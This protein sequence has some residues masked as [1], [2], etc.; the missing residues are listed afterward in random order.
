VGLGILQK[1]WRWFEKLDRYLSN[2]GADLAALCIFGMLVVIT[3]SSIGR[4]LF[5]INIPNVDEFSGYALVFMTYLGLAYGL[6]TGSHIS[7]D[8][9]RAKLPKSVAVG[10]E[11]VTC[12]IGLFVVGAYF[13]FALDALMESLRIGERALTPSETPLWI[14]RSAICVGW[15]FMGL[16]M[17][18]LLVVKLRSFLK[19]LMKGD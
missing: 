2:A 6:K 3:V 8:L 11:V 14:P 19:N 15:V 12:F 13:F 17:L 1:I 7:I 9:V 16:S 10:M 4:Y 5:N 18:H